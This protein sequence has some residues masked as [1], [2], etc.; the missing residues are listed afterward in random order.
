LLVALSTLKSECG[1]EKVKAFAVVNDRALKM[2]RFVL[3]V[4]ALFAS[5][6]GDYIG[7]KEIG[8]YGEF[9]F[10]N[11]LP[12]SFMMSFRLVGQ[13]DLDVEYEKTYHVSSYFK[14]S[15][16]NAR[17]FCKTYGMDLMALETDSEKRNFDKILSSN[18]QSFAK[19]THIGGIVLQP[20]TPKNWHWITTQKPVTFDIKYAAGN[21]SSS[22]S[23]EHC[24]CFEK[25]ANEMLFHDV[26]CSTNSQSF[27]CEERFI[28]VSAGMK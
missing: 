28:S 9:A 2:N 6:C 21:P 7:F 14:E 17:S 15:W 22:Q 27:I 23:Q 13:D 4:A 24:L 12:E 11:N 10:T 20:G 18:F 25:A 16:T 19:F 26:V 1:R 8:T 5:C 3:L